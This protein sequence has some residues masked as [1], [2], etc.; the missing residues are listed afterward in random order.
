MSQ[1]K[2]FT[3]FFEQSNGSIDELKTVHSE[4]E[5]QHLVQRAQNDGYEAWY[6]DTT[7]EVT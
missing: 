1:V 3:V 2:Y 6:E 4:Q 5:A 7:E